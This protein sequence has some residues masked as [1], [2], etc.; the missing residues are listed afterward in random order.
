MEFLATLLADGPLAQQNIE[1]QYSNEGHS[2]STIRRAKNLLKIKSQKKGGPLG[3]EEQEWGLV[4][5][6]V[7]Q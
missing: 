2:E 5:T 7:H 3:D 4:I 1:K 6:Y